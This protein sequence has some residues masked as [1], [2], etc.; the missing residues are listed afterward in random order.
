[1]K[2]LLLQIGGLS[3]QNIIFIALILVLVFLLFSDVLKRSGALKLTKPVIKTELTCKECGFK[4]IRDFREGDYISKEDPQK[5][6]R[7]GGTMIVTKI[8]AVE[9]KK[10]KS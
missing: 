7:C 10:T 9:V 4:Y 5:C 3:I 1:M 8:Y 6:Q 2:E